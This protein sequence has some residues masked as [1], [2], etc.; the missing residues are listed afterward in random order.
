MNQVA[1]EVDLI[2]VGAGA[3]GM[4]AALT[5]ALHG[6]RIVLCEATEQ[7]GGTTA[8]SAGTIWVPGNRHGAQ[9]GFEDSI[10]S[11]QR[12]LDTL[13]GPDDERGLR[14][15]Y[16]HS[17]NAAIDF[18]ES[19]SE[20][21]F[22]TAGRHPDYLE[23][24]GAA[25]SG[26]ALAPVEFDGRLLGGDFD[27]IRAPLPDF[28]LFGG[29]MA[30]KADVQALIHRY[31]SVHN[32]MHSARLMGR[33]ALD[34]LRRRRGTRLVM[35]NALVARL[36]HSLNAAKVDIR[37]GMRLRELDVDAGRVV[38]AVLDHDR[39]ALHLS[40]RIGVV[41]ATGGIGHH[42]ALRTA[43]A[44]TGVD[45]PSIRTLAFKGN[46]GEGIQAA[47][48]AGAALDRHADSFFWQ[49]VSIVP[50]SHGK[51]SLF[52]HL[53]LDRSKPGL[54]AVNAKGKRFV[55]EG[56]S[57]HHF[58]EEMLRAQAASSGVPAYLVCDAAFVR[59]YG[60]GVIAPGTRNLGRYEAN[61]YL[62]LAPT[63]DALAARLGIDP[64]SQGARV[65]RNN[66]HA[67]A[68]ADPDFGK[69]STELSRFNGDAAHRPNACLGPID[70]PPFCALPVWPA[71][72]ASS[73]GL[74]TNADGAVLDEAGSP[75]PG[76]YA[77]GNDMASIMRGTYPG[78]GIT[79]GPAMVFGYRI[80][81][82]AAR[83]SQP[84]EVTPRVTAS[85]DS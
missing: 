19:Q 52:P 79:I 16:L 68:G 26:R 25:V 37:F 29:M 61:D 67:Q 53:Y 38:G 72:A 47:L 11:A 83:M 14:H 34:R 28:L 54:I 57:Y 76:L 43:L 12:Y 1:G 39:R 63:I 21:K 55:N 48:N 23:L 46:R 64:A 7:V 60:L 65:A 44:P 33:Y 49:P 24:P 69:G 40:S 82:H 42:A 58:V 31:R 9:A 74:K 77:C 51:T 20:V 5:A 70:T 3:A 6:L 66:S 45:Q 35:G 73:T 36:F 56:A 4:T 78:P 75:M 17:A 8:T 41:L 27:R 50:K 85:K 15:A 84:P 2:V 81:L 62:V 10:E 32:F 59:T 22:S 18:L 30:G 13:L 80:G 71:E